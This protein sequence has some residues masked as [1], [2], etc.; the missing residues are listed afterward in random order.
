MKV[1][2]LMDKYPYLIFL[3][4]RKIFNELVTSAMKK[5]LFWF[6]EDDGLIC[7]M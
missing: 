4:E 6:V 7:T 2:N 1:E 5:W 3:M